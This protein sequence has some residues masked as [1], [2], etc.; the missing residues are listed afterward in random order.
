[1]LFALT[2]SSGSSHLVLENQLKFMELHS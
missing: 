1:M 2:P